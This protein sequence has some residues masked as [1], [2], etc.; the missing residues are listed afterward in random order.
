MHLDW[1]TLA[2]QAINALILIWLLAYFLFRPVADIIATRQK[3][4]YQLLDEAQAAKTAAEAEREKAAAKEA[5]LENQRFAALKAAQAE[6]AT[7]K[8][9]MLAAAQ[10]DADKLRAVAQAEIASARQAEA[11]AAEDRAARLAVDIA[12]KLLDRLPREARV[13]AFIDGIA[14]GLQKLPE[15]ARASLGVGGGAI[16][17]TAARPVTPEEV[18]LCRDAI[19]RVLGH[20]VTIEIAVKPELIAGLELDGPHAS[21]RNSFRADLARLKSE[22]VHRA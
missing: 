20:P 12:G 9:E 18:E 7:A 10:A 21:V 14:T 4:A 16:R 3:T 17:L 15:G 1:S 13:A 11:Q 6:A 5:E 22:L 8:A 2:L 19:A